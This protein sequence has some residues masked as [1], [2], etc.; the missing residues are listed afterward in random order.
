M[1]RVQPLLLP[2]QQTLPSPALVFAKRKTNPF[3]FSASK[4]VT[5]TSSSSSSLTTCG[6]KTELTTPSALLKFV[7]EEKQQQQPSSDRKPQSPPSHPLTSIQTKTTTATLSHS[8]KVKQ[9][10]KHFELAKENVDTK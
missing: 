5:S 2:R 3:A 7:K 1:A 6:T 9:E 4:S 8:L 10:P